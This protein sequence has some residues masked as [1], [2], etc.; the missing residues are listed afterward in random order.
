MN[1]AG[2]FRTDWQDEWDDGEPDL[3]H[4]TPIPVAAGRQTRHINVALAPF[5]MSGTI[6]GAVRDT[7]GHILPDVCVNV[8]ALHRRL[9]EGG[10]TRADG[11]YAIAVHPGDYK[12]QFVP[13]VHPG[14]AMSWYRN[15]AAFRSADIVH[16]RHATTRASVN[17]TLPRL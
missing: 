3:A 7:A 17:G 13:C 6:A 14:Y 12:V 16:V 15:K 4:A 11:T 8:Y 2:G 1:C 9:L 10:G 5:D